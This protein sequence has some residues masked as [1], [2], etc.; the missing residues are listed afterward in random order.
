MSKTT[1]E[2]ALCGVMTALGVVLLCLGGIIPFAMYACP[3]LASAVLVAVRREC[4]IGYAWVCFAATAILGM[5]LGPDKESAALYLFLGYYPLVKPRLDTVRPAAF[6]WGLKLAVAVAA[7]GVIYAL[8]IYVLALQ[9]VA[10]DF[11]N[12]AP[13]VFWS[14]IGMGLALFVVYDILLGRFDRYYQRRRRRG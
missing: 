12:A 14:S 10:E 11:V 9:Q 1:K 2:L 6:R 3:I 5:V 13:W 7:V 8:L 4:R